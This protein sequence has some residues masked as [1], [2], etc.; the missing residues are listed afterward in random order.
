MRSSPAPVDSALTASV[1]YWD[2][3]GIALLTGRPGIYSLAHVWLARLALRGFQMH[4]VDCAIRA[5]AEI[6]TEEA[7]RRG[8]APELLLQAITVQRAFT[9]YQ[10]LDVL[11][12]ELERLDEEQRQEKNERIVFVMA[13]CKQF[14]DPDVA[15]DECAFLLNKLLALV[16]LYRQRGPALLLVESEAYP[17]DQFGPVLLQLRAL[18]A[19]L[20]EY[21]QEIEQQT[22]ALSVRRR[23]IRGGFKRT[24][25]GGGP[26]G[27]AKYQ[28]KGQVSYGPNDY[29]LFNSDADGGGSPERFQAGF[30]AG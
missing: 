1:R 26:G 14:F 28:L 11:G 21:H 7:L 25:A 20:F 27:G 19:T 5:D 22:Y 8:V 4:V 30:A 6:L 18:A 23:D 2:R 16:R 9:P 24:I 29:A 17:S 10:I 13:P 15:R 12:A 3:R